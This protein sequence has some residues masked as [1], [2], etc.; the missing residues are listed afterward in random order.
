MWFVT[1]RKCGV[2]MLWIVSCLY[3]CC[4]GCLS[5][6]FSNFWKHW[7]W[8]FSLNVHSAH[9]SSEYLGHVY[10]SKSS[11][12]GQDHRS[13]RLYKCHQVQTFAAG[14]PLTGRQSCYKV[15]AVCTQQYQWYDSS[16]LYVWLISHCPWNL[17][18]QWKNKR[19][20]SVVNLRI[21]VRRRN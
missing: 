11:G 1:T 13:K 19:K 15:C 17:L 12:Q 4:C 20:Q 5:C 2:L 8:N 10:I 16:A 18:C 7:R 21:E 3:V 9:T 14:P 6:S